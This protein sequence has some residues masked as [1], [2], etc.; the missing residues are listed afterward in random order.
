[1]VSKAGYGFMDEWIKLASWADLNELK[2]L[3]S[4]STE[5]RETLNPWPLQEHQVMYYRTVFKIKQY[6]LP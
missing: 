5:R 6:L 2:A 3:V 4:H 1:M